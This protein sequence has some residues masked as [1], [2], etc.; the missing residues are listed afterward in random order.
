TPRPAWTPG[1]GAGPEP[2]AGPGPD[3]RYAPPRRCGEGTRRSGP[4]PRPRACRT[5][6][7]AGRRFPASGW[8]G[9]G[10]PTAAGRDGRHAEAG[11]PGAAALARSTA[12]TTSS[13][14]AIRTRATSSPVTGLVENSRPSPPTGRPGACVA[15]MTQHPDRGGAAGR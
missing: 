5:R 15:I 6:G 12:T 2:D 14:P 11:P 3:A 4:P 13:A 9:R 10:R 7:P 8:P 1:P